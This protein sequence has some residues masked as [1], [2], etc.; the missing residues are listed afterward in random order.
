MTGKNTYHDDDH[1][2]VML[3]VQTDGVTLGL[4][5]VDPNTHV[6]SVSDGTTGSDNGPVNAKHD[7]NNIAIIMG[8]SS[9]D[10]KTPVAPYI[11]SSGAWLIDSN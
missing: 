7:G 11:D 5:Q 6:L 10:G 4:P 3:A 8:V 9:A 2:H 1:V